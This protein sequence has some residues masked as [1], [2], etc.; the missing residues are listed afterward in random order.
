MN[1]GIPFGAGPRVCLGMSFS[2]MEQ[3]VVLTMLLWRYSWRVIGN[4]NALQGQP[5]SMMGVLF[6]P[7]NIQV[8]FTRGC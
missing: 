3:R 6:K 5:D 2:W 4:E 8:Q 7:K 1:T